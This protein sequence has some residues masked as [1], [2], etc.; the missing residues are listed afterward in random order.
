[1]WEWSRRVHEHAA[2]ASWT[3][4]RITDPEPTILDPETDADRDDG[5]A[6]GAA[7]GSMTLSG[8][9]PFASGHAVVVTVVASAP[10]RPDT[11]DL[12]G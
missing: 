1:M 5:V 7:P 3:R 12:A 10:D 11:Y 8:A 9:A 2:A 6:E 4:W